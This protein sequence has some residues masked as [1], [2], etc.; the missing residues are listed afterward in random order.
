MFL[1]D[2]SK[3]ITWK[4]PKIY[5]SIITFTVQFC[6]YKL[7]IIIITPNLHGFRKPTSQDVKRAKLDWKSRTEQDLGLKL[8]V[9]SI[10]PSE[11]NPGF[12]WRVGK[13][14]QEVETSLARNK[15]ARKQPWRTNQL[16]EFIIFPYQIL[17]NIIEYHKENGGILRVHYLNSAEIIEIHHTSIHTWR[18][19]NHL[20]RRTDISIHRKNKDTDLW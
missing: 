12:R 8:Q 16:H 7:I 14:Q 10:P 20:W 2:N 4:L 17:W 13:M 5:L 15:T 6:N 9:W 18:V 3:Y 19:K 11:K 1:A